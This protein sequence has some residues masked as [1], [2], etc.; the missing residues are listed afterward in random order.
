MITK[1]SLQ[2]AQ[3]SINEGL[4]RVRQ[5]Y[6]ASPASKKIFFIVEGKDDVPFYG[7]KADGYI[8]SG[9]K[10]VIIPAKNR[11]KVVEVYNSLDWSHYSKNK[12]MFFID[13]D[14]S[15]YTKEDTPQDTNVYVTDKYAIENDLCTAD[16][17]LK[18]LKYYYDLVDIDEKDEDCLQK[19]FTESCEKFVTMSTPVMAQI[20]HWKLNRIKANYAN[21]KAQNIFEINNKSF[22]LVETYQS[23]HSILLELCKQSGVPYSP[24]DILE[25]I[26]LLNE[27]HTPE[28]YIRGKYILAFFVKILN[29]T[30]KNSSNI[31]PSSRKSKDNLGLGYENALSKL[32]GIMKSPESLDKFLVRMKSQLLLETA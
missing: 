23:E 14:L 3:A 1:E 4:L 28:E 18:A 17:Y 15:D 19:F 26:N 10:L 29:F 21:F 5:S 22:Q 30:T 11:K 9:W 32:C 12:I 2:L 24:I 16:T 31:L 6:S 8:P 27:K 13:Q 7:T 25:Y 20:L